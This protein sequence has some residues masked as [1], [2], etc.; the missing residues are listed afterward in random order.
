MTLVV[1]SAAL[2]IRAHHYLWVNRQ[3]RTLYLHTLPAWKLWMEGTSHFFEPRFT[4]NF[5]IEISVIT[6]ALQQSLEE[7]IQVSLLL[8]TSAGNGKVKKSLLFQRWWKCALKPHVI[9]T[10]DSLTSSDAHF[11]SLWEAL[12]IKAAF[13]HNSTPPPHPQVL[14]TCGSILNRLYRIRL[15]MSPLSCFSRSSRIWHVHHM[16]PSYPSVATALG[17]S[18]HILLS[19]S[20]RGSALGPP[21]LYVLK[22]CHSGL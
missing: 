11:L 22:L 16:N 5:N 12:I 15:L 19:A 9:C 13:T 20:L 1:L 4:L 3:I 8:H 14:S 6:S 2:R 17:H 10:T 7:S 18:L 21:L